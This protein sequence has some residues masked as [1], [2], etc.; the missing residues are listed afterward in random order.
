[1]ILFLLCFGLNKESGVGASEMS[2]LSNQPSHPHESEPGW[3]RLLAPG[4]LGS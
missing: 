3:N 2:A 1:M 4:L